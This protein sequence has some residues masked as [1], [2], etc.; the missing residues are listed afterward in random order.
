M[1]KMHKNLMIPSLWEDWVENAPKLQYYYM[2]LNQLLELLW[3][4]VDPKWNELLGVF[5]SE[6]AGIV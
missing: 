1:I 4:R 3:R 5:L 6:N 2:E